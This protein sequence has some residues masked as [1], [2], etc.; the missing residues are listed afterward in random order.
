MALPH[1]KTCYTCREH[2]PLELFHRD[3]GDLL[4]R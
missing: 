2:L 3:T 1:S 4:E